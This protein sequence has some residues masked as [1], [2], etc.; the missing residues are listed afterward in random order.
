M[1]LYYYLKLSGLHGISLSWYI[2]SIVGSIVINQEKVVLDL[3]I[4][5]CVTM[6][7]FNSCGVGYVIMGTWH[8]YVG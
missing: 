3:Y 1:I 6:V 8:I 4:I 5:I 7:S 2:I